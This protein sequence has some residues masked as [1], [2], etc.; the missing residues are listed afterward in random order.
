[1]STKKNK[2][3]RKFNVWANLRQTVSVEIVADSLEDALAK[4]KNLDE[5]VFVDVL[6][7]YVDG[8][9]E[10]TGVLADDAD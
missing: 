3:Q 9:F 4:A 10:I 2:V 5:K 7:E 6:G 1:M 8:N